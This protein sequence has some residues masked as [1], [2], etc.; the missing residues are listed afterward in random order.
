MTT[1]F[2]DADACPVKDEAYRVAARY[3]VPVIVVANRWLRIPASPAIRLQL[4]AGEPDAA[5]NW[6][7]GETTGSDVVV[8]ADVPLADRVLKK[9][10]QVV[11]PTGRPLTPDTIGSAL[12]SRSIGEHL[13]SIGAFTGGPKS[14]AASDRSRFLQV[15]DAAIARARRR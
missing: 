8:T 12:A 3:E 10:A 14:F 6:I 2:I 13:R 11:H 9:G 7:A 4:V 15:L 5:D 1:L